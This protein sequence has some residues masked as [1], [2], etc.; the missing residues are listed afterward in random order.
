MIDCIEVLNQH[1][2]EEHKHLNERLVDV[3]ETLIEHSARI[4]ALDKEVS[5]LQSQ[6][7]DMSKLQKE[8]HELVHKI[9]ETFPKMITDSRL[10]TEESTEKQFV[11]CRE[12]QNLKNE[13]SFLKLPEGFYGSIVRILIYVLAGIGSWMGIGSLLK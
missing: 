9:S 4:N 1:I 12:L 6:L 7:S 3:R 10:K 2:K 5:M 8:T 13:K 11:K